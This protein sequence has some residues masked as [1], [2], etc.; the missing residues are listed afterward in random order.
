[1]TMICCCSMAGT[2]ACKNCSR[3]KEYF[4]ESF[5]RGEFYEVVSRPK[6]KWNNKKRYSIMCSECNC[7]IPWQTGEW[8]L[9]NYCPNCGA[10][11]GSE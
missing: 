4:G 3:Y 1:M 5:S 9:P 7:L 6:G 8:R 2:Q 11:M 10:E